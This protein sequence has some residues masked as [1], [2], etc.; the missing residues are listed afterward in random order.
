MNKVFKRFGA[1]IMMVVLFTTS[2]GFTM[3]SHMCFMDG[4]QSVSASKIDSCCPMDESTASATLTS[5]C[6]D[7]ETNFY[8]LDYQASVQRSDDNGFVLMATFLFQSFTA[9]ET[10]IVALTN[11]SPQPPPKSGREILSDIRTLQI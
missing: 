1:Y 4:Q 11:Y 2:T 6:C 8:K 7:D 3:F 10:S 9:S 5:D